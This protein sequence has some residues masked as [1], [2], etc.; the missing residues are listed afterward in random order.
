MTRFLEYQTLV[1]LLILLN[2]VFL[3]S[4]RPLDILNIVSCPDDHNEGFF[5]RFSLGSIK[6][7]PSPGIG[8]GFVDK[9]TLGGIKDGPSPGIGHG[10]ALGGIKDGPSPGIGHKFVN[11]E[12]LGGHKNSGPSPGEGH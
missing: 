6:D 10:Y 1:I 3:T 11:V 7:G 5:D 2:M 12:T 4:A 9:A 8:H